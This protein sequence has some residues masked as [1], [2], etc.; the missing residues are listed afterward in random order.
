MVKWYKYH[1]LFKCITLGLF[2]ALFPPNI[3]DNVWLYECI[4]VCVYLDC[5]TK[6][7]IFYK[8]NIRRKGHIFPLIPSIFL[9]PKTY[10]ESRTL[11]ASNVHLNHRSN[12]KWKHG[13][14]VRFI[15]RNG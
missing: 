13:T 5:I 6:V 10:S 3:I 15:I 12:D 7:I 4:Y 8:K 11:F 1:A 9:S 14:Y 2:V